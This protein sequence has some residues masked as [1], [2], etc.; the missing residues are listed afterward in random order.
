MNARNMR[1]LF[2]MNSLM[3][4]V[5]SMKAANLQA[6]FKG[7]TMPFGESAFNSVSLRI[8]RLSDSLTDEDQLS[9]KAKP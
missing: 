5:E 8:D 2:K 3:V 4:I 9:L 7:E 1:L 6:E